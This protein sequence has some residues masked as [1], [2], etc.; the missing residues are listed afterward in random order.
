MV[1]RLLVEKHLVDKKLENFD[2]NADAS[3]IWPTGLSATPSLVD[4]SGGFTEYESLFVLAKFFSAKW[5]SMKRRG[6]V[7][8]SFLKRILINFRKAAFYIRH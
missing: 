8:R 4:M 2:R 5:F 3:V 6:K 7:D 1:R